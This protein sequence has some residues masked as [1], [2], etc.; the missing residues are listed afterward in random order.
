M[1]DH[2]KNAQISD[3]KVERH[4]S[5]DHHSQ[6][7]PIPTVRLPS[8]TKP[9]PIVRLPPIPL[10]APSDQ[11]HNSN[12]PVNE[13]S[14]LARPSKNNHGGPT[15]LAATES[16]QN[17]FKQL[18]GSVN[19]RQQRPPSPVLYDAFGD[20]IGTTRSHSST[21]TDSIVPE[22]DKHDYQESAT[23]TSPSTIAEN[24]AASVSSETAALLMQGAKANWE[25]VCKA[26]LLDVSLG[27]KEILNQ[28]ML[29]VNR[30]GAGSGPLSFAHQPRFEGPAWAAAVAI[31][32]ASVCTKSS[33]EE[34]I[35]TMI[36]GAATQRAVDLGETG[37]EDEEELQARKDRIALSLVMR[38]QEQPIKK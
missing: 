13:M 5:V 23:S 7:K 22:E 30:L 8:R 20:P 2:R 9:V 1:Q 24:P 36:R 28:I 31:G 12:N 16:W 25:N 35:G 15:P 34:P 32:T 19:V 4:F 14:Y 3:V 33:V 38:R 27:D 29:L 26:L 37:K 17:R 18:T 10:K 21:V 11:T 6:N